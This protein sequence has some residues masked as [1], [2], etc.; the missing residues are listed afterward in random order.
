LTAE[1]KQKKINH[2]PTNFLLFES[3]EPSQNNHSIF[4]E[5]KDEKKEPLDKTEAEIKTNTILPVKTK[6]KKE[7][8]LCIIFN[9]C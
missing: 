7:L 8:T 2:V 4:T 5:T 1:N 9:Y 6:V 3:N